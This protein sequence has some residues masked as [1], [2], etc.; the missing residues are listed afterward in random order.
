MR[1][2][3]VVLG[4]KRYIINLLYLKST[5][6]RGIKNESDGEYAVELKG[7]NKDRAIDVV[8]PDILEKNMK[9]I[10]ES[11]VSAGTFDGKI[12]TKKGVDIKTITGLLLTALKVPDADDLLEK[13]FPED[14]YKDMRQQI[15]KDE[16][17]NT[18]PG[19]PIGAPGQ[20]IIPTVPEGQPVIP[21]PGDNDGKPQLPRPSVESM[22]VSAVQELTRA[23]SNSEE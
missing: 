10:V 20:E 12:A 9:D 17:E 1:I 5:I 16:D 7:R 8:F 22:M 11:V 13:L 21:P 4:V 15:Q 23:V 3:Y 2:I 18:P 19:P 14:I 6:L